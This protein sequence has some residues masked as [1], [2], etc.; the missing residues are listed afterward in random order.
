MLNSQ[1]GFS[2]D[3]YLDLQGRILQRLRH[4]KINDQVFEVLQNAYEKAL[5]VDELVLNR[6]E[7]KRLL[8]DVMK[9]VF[10]EMNKQLDEG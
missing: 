4:A 5:S 8:G 3:S 9:S 1:S 6:I 2:S 10:A 7:K